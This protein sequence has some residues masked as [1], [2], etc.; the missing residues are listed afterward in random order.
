M[1]SVFAKLNLPL[2]TSRRKAA[3]CFIIYFLSHFRLDLWFNE[4]VRCETWCFV[5]LVQ[6]K[7]TIIQYKL[8]ICSLSTKSD[9]ALIRQIKN[10]N[11]NFDEIV[12]SYNFRISQNRCII[13]IEKHPVFKTYTVV[14]N[15]IRQQKTI[16]SWINGIHR[17]LLQLWDYSFAWCQLLNKQATTEFWLFV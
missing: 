13:I 2:V 5:E 1:A 6:R 8:L 17:F 15:K 16:F 4:C 3:A 9:T 14:M 10:P 7:Q 11:I 12:K